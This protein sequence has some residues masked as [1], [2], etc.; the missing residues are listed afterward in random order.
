MSKEIPQRQ[1]VMIGLVVILVL[2]L[3]L[4][5]GGKS[6]SSG[7]SSGGFIA[8]LNGQ[9]LEQKVK[10]YKSTLNEYK[11]NIQEASKLDIIRED[12]QREQGDFWSYSDNSSPRSLIQQ[13]IQAL[14][15]ETDLRTL[16]VGIGSERRLSEST[17]MLYAD[18][19]VNGTLA[20]DDMSNLADFLKAI[21]DQRQKYHWQS[22]QIYTRKYRDKISLTLSSKIRVY[23]LNK[24]AVTAMKEEE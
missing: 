16:R 18:Y 17:Y 24:K 23:I 21:E 8:M 14:L 20:M 4:G 12:L 5:I 6:K 10:E 1:K 19:T 11:L 15:K 2:Y 9:D 22:F 13:K 7:K 3:V